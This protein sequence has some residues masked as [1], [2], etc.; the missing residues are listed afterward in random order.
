M[1]WNTVQASYN[2]HADGSRVSIAMSRVSVCVCD[3][4]I[5]SLCPHDNQISNVNKHL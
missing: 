5:L 2:I 4:V 1:F 3:P